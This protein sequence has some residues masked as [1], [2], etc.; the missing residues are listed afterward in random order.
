MHTRPRLYSY[1]EIDVSVYLTTEYHLHPLHFKDDDDLLPLRKISCDPPIGHTDL[2]E[3]PL[4][5]MP[6]LTCS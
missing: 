6:H 4:P 3:L 2:K 5:G 1:L